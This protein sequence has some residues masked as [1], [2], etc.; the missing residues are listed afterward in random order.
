MNKLKGGC[1]KKLAV[2]MMVLFGLTLFRSQSQIKTTELWSFDINKSS[3]TLIW[4]E[5]TT[6][7]DK[8]T[9]ESFRIYKQE[10]EV[11][12]AGDIM[13]MGETEGTFIPADA[14]E[15]IITLFP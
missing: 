11:D 3:F 14:T 13:Y 8:D 6:P 10:Y 9:P 15:E 2:S 4:K 12:S 1:M 5:I 7:L